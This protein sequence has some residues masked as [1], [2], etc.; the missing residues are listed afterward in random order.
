MLGITDSMRFDFTKMREM[1]NRTRFDSGQGGANVET[2]H[3]SMNLTTP[4]GHAV[5]SKTNQRHSRGVLS[6]RSLCE[7]VLSNRGAS[8]FYLA[9]ICTYV[10]ERILYSV[11]IIF[12]HWSRAWER[13]TLFGGVRETH[14]PNS[15][16]CKQQEQGRCK[17]CSCNFRDRRP[18]ITWLAYAPSLFDDFDNK[19]KIIQRIKDVPLS[20]NTMKDRILNLAENVTDQQKND[21]NS[22]PFISLCLDE[23]IDI[24]KLFTCRNCGGGDRGRVAI[25]RPFGEVSLSLNRTVTCMVLKANDRRTSC[26]C[27]NE[28]RGPRSDYV[29]QVALATTTTVKKYSVQH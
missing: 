18:P 25:Y 6:A 22:A 17:N 15:V 2:G 19:D 9:A 8:R 26:P 27:H 10:L 29:R 3:Q 20:R 11:C 7:R 14:S 23:S 21:I 13:V 16:S 12:S 24:T 1:S 5:E 28:F 4:R